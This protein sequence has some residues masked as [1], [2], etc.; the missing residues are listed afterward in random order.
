MY[1]HINQ[2]LV[3][4]DR[5]FCF[6]LQVLKYGKRSM[7]LLK[8]STQYWKV[9]RNN[10]TFKL[11]V[12]CVTWRSTA[13]SGLYIITKQYQCIMF[14]WVVHIKQNISMVS[15]SGLAQKR[16]NSS[17]NTLEL[18]LFCTNLLTYSQLKSIIPELSKS[19][20]VRG[21]RREW[22]RVHCSVLL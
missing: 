11:I 19:W 5:C 12:L 3:G 7:K 22:S 18:H 1:V 21:Y 17:A 14:Y 16:C 13:T 20:P 15:I 6:I 10:N 4:I 8:I 2:F 9:S